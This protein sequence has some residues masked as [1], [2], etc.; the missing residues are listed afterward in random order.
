[1]TCVDHDLA[2]C[3]MGVQQ[4]LGIFDTARTFT[5][6]CVLGG[7]SLATGAHGEP[8]VFIEAKPPPINACALLS[9]VAVTEATGF[10]AHS[11]DRHDSGYQTNGSYSSTCVWTLEREKSGSGQTASLRGRS[12]V[13][14]NV[15][16]WPEG[17]GLADSFLQ[18]FH[19]A[20]ARGEIPGEPTPR[21]FGDAALWWGDGLAVRKGDVSFGISVVIPDKE[22]GPPGEL[23]GRLVPK[24]L[25]QLEHRTDD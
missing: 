23:E 1:M 5:A 10:P 8:G 17:S 12:F 22:A 15:M 20:A 13:I 4:K 24:I 9:S 7:W 2:V 3:R 18:A 14:L 16:R 21:D 25:Q 6:C 19:E 11:G